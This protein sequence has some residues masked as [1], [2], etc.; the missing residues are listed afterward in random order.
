MGSHVRFAIATNDAFPTQQEGLAIAKWATPRE[1]WIER[2]NAASSMPPSSTPLQVTEI[3][4]DNPLSRL[5]L[6]NSGI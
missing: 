1:D 6:R 3:P 4:Q 5:L 2:E